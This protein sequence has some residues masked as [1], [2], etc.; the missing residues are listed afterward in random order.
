VL[1]LDELPEYP[2]SVLESLRQPLEDKVISISRSHGRII[3]PADFMLVATMNPCSCGYF[4]DPDRECTCSN[5]QVLAYN[6]R[7]SGPLLDRIDMI[8]TVSKVNHSELLMLNS[9]NKK[10]QSKVVNPIHSATEQQKYRYDSSVIYNSSL[11][12]QEVKKWLALSPSARQILTTAADRLHLTARSYFKV[13]K[14][15]RTIA[16]LAG[17]QQIEAPHVSEALQFRGRT[18]T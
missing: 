2:R 10:Q 4:G 17:S 7:L 3:Y 13:I 11:S 14:V 5:A 12:S 1:F 8:I 6:K 18:G 16:D 15:A 9:L